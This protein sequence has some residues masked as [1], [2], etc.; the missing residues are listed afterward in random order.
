M[1]P[2]PT[3]AEAAAAA[4]ERQVEQTTRPEPKLCRIDDPDCEACQ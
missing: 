2:T 1:G 4:P 3:I